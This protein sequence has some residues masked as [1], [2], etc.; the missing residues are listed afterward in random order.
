MKRVFWIAVAVV[1][2]PSLAFGAL[3]I[4]VMPP[5]NILFI[6]PWIALMMGAVGAISNRIA[7]ASAS[8]LV[9]SLPERAGRLARP[10]DERLVKG[11]LVAEAE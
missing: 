1:V 11:A 5:I 7:E 6:P 10:A 3:I 8:R 9:S 2:Y 4:A